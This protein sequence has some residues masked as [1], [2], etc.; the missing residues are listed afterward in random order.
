MQT[1]LEFN[2]KLNTPELDTI[3]AIY[4]KG[5]RMYRYIAFRKFKNYKN[6]INNS[7]IELKIEK[8]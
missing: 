1:F 3:R 8:Q 6:L 7:L 4:Y 2:E 5:Q